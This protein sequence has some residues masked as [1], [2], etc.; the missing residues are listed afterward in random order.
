MNTL[1]NI[2]IAQWQQ[3]K[4]WGWL[5]WP[6]AQI[7]SLIVLFRQYLYK[8]NIL[9]SYKA[10]LPVIIV[11]NIS[12]GGTGKTPLVI[13]FSELLQQMGL[14]PGIVLR[15]YKSRA[16]GTIFVDK[17]SDPKF[18]GDE[19][20]LLAQRC[21]C[22]VVIDKR[23]VNAVKQLIAKCDVDI[24]LC[25]DGLQHYALQRDIEIAV[26]DIKQ[27]FGNG[28]CLPMGPLREP[29]QRLQKVDINITNG[30]DMHL[31]FGKIYPLLRLHNN[32]NK[33]INDFVGQKV[34]AV[35]G[36]GMPAKFF[37]ALAKHDIE[38]V[39]HAYP[40]HHEFRMQDINFADNLPVLMTEKDAV[41]CRYFANIQ[42]WS[43][44]VT[45]IVT[46]KIK[47][48]FMKRVQEAIHDR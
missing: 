21:N 44:T 45:A 13:Y 8:N 36:I 1:Q 28:Y 31:E 9:S 5:L 37:Q 11:G 43:V 30:Q 17:N 46:E 18:V 2:L 34:H 4:F 39:P 35:A 20:V 32:A 29:K 33:T 19:A 41:K 47:D 14:R 3:Q 15:G 22:P 27:G 38:V 6:F 26:S 7:F 25:D 10:P 23:R 42:H 48:Q 16:I 12:V 24:I 40:D